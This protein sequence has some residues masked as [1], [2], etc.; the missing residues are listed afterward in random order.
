MREDKIIDD[1]DEDEQDIEHNDEEDNDRFSGE[2]ELE[3]DV[4]FFRDNLNRNVGAGNFVKNLY[5]ND[6]LFKCCDL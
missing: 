3:E 1:N 2:Q 6:F 4:N 5:F